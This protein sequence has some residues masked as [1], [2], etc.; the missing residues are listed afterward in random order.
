MTATNS[1]DAPATG[2]EPAPQVI[3]GIT[4]ALTCVEPEYALEPARSRSDKNA[5]GGAQYGD[6][7]SIGW[8]SYCLHANT[9]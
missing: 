7:L 1:F 3:G 5:A 6:V 2:A 4:P 8:E 9:P